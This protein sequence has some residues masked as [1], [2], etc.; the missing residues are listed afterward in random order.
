MSLQ[1][2]DMDLKKLSFVFW[3]ALPDGKWNLDDW[4]SHVS[5]GLAHQIIHAATLVHALK[6]NKK[7]N[8][9]LDTVNFL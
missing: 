1:L 6:W 8:F 3:H 4:Q 9:F 5:C 2:N 7:E